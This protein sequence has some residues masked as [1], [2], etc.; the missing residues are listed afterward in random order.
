MD[1]HDRELLERQMRRFVP[2]PLKRGT[3]MLSI[4]ATFLAGVTLGS[5]MSMYRDHRLQTAANDAP[6]TSPNHTLPITR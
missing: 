4:V 2:P 6:M 1:Q 5:L 3:M